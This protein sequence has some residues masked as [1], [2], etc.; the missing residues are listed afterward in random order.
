MEDGTIVEY[1]IDI[2][3][4]KR[5]EAALR[6]S[7]QRFKLIADNV[8]DYAI[9]TL[10][11]AGKVTSWNPGAQRIFRYT[12]A[13]I[14]GQNARELFTP[15][16]RAKGKHEK[17]LRTAATE[18]R[19]S[20]DRW[21]MRKGGEKFWASGVTT[22]MR[23][24]ATGGR[25]LGFIKICR[26]DT[27]RK[28]AED[29]LK[30]A[31]EDLERRVGVRTE[32]MRSHQRQLRSLVAELGREEIRQRRLIATELHDN[33][34]KLLAVCKMRVS[35]IEAQLGKD[36]AAAK[37]EAAAVKDSLGEAIACTRTLMTDLR[38]DVLD[39]HDLP[40]AVEWVA[41][42]MSRHG[43]KV[44]V[45]DD[46]QAKPIEEDVLG[47]LFQAVRELLWN[48]VK[49]A[50]TTE[51]SVRIE[52]LDE[53]VR[54]TVDDRGVGFNPSKRAVLPTEH[55]GYGL[56]SIAERVDLLGGQMSVDSAPRRGTQVTL[57]VP[58]DVDGGDKTGAGDGDGEG[59]GGSS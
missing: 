35:A 4:W 7:E 59:E 19:A 11:P 42:R 39:A 50:R 47:F 25:L 10:D 12:A 53:Q 20:D 58:L 2:S 27:N 14:I 30:A 28:A 17:E 1:C 3:E 48:V 34:A 26:D 45:I 21:Q 5:T 43:L 16:D 29:Q 9:F 46:A 18:G 52:R 56:F 31:N 8:R 57:T 41:Q 36:P 44:N 55:G 33:L 54:V 23:D 37:Q 49:H 13:E 40:A 22:A 6:G 51:A 38:P 24:A 32:S 15:E